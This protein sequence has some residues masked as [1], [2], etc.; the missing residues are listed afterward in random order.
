MPQPCVVNHPCE[1]N[2]GIR[3]MGNRYGPY[4][5]WAGLVAGL[6]VAAVLLNWR[7]GRQVLQLQTQGFPP[8]KNR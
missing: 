5:F 1:C 3:W 6:A 4:G 7:L 8:D 2:N